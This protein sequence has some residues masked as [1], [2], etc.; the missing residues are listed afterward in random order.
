MR[1]TVPPLLERARDV[2]LE[3]RL[4]A[5]CGG[6]LSG[7]FRI[8]HNGER[9]KIIA[10]EAYPP[11]FPWEHVSVSTPS[12]IPSWAGMCFVKDLFWEPEEAVMQLHPP[13]SQYVNNHPWT[14]HLWRPTD[15]VIPLP[16]PIMVGPRPGG[17]LT[18]EELAAFDPRR[19]HG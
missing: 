5:A 10:S 2:A 18:K 1:K 13:A 9:L 17:V 7:C 4:Q 19:M 11:E 3:A 6:L 12:R 15:A 8:R 14:L 16:P